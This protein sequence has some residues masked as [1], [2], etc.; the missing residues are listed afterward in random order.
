[1]SRFRDDCPPSKQKSPNGTYLVKPLLVVSSMT[2]EVKTIEE[3]LAIMQQTLE[4]LAKDDKEK[5]V[6]IKRQD[7]KIASLMQR[8]KKHQ[9]KRSSDD[10]SDGE[11]KSIGTK[12]RTLSGSIS[13]QQIQEM[14]SSAIKTY[15]GGGSHEIHLH[16]KPY[17][18]RIDKLQ[19]PTSYQPPNFQQFDGKGNPKQHIVH[20]IETCN[21]AGTEGDLLVKQF[22]RSLKGVAFEWYTDMTP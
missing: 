4:K 10:D 1:M 20:F 15:V 19:M 16:T 6:I 13:I 2:T 17:T 5:D 22:V 9:E 11:S 12:N 8:L 7:Q 3:Q 18:K 14:V 21:S